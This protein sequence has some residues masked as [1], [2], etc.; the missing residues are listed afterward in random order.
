MVISGLQAGDVIDLAGVGFVSG[1][2]VTP[3]SGGV[4]QVVENSQTYD[5]NTQYNEGSV[6]GLSSDGHSGTDIT[7]SNSPLFRSAARRSAATLSAVA[8]PSNSRLA[9]RLLARPF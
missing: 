4:L 9:V 3:L 7:V 5:L 8:S 2:S 6:F 1:G